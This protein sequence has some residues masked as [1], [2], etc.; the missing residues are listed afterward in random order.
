MRAFEELAPRS[1]GQPGQLLDIVLGRDACGSCWAD[2]KY[3][4]PRDGADTG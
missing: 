2:S 4:P 1:A 3:N